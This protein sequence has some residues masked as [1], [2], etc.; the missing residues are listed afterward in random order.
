MTTPDDFDP[1]NRWATEHYGF[2]DDGP[3]L[4]D[5]K[6]ASARGSASSLGGAR[7]RART[8]ARHRAQG[9]RHPMALPAAGALVAASVVSLAMVVGGI[10]GGVAAA[11]VSAD[12]D[13]ASGP[14]VRDG[15]AVR[16]D[17][18]PG[19]HGGGAAA[20]RP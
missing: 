17:E 16:F 15:V 5:A 6:A 2:D 14:R 18:D 4:A 9:R 7:P 20:G 19:V 12:G 10:G 1:V 13:Q 8:R 3:L 11:G